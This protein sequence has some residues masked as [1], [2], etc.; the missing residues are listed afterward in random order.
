M[1]YGLK[2]KN[3]NGQIQIDATYKNYCLYEHGENVSTILLE[4]TGAI[5][6][7][8]ITFNNATP[9]PPLIAIKPSASIYCGLYSYTKSGNNYTGFIVR[10]EAG[11]SATIDWMAFVPNETASSAAY[12]MRVY[13]ASGVLVFDSGYS[14]MVILDVDTATPGY[15]SV[16]TITHPSNANAYFIMHSYG[17]Y[18]LTSAGGPT[19]II[20]RL[21]I[22]MFKYLSDT[23][24]SFGGKM[25]R[26]DFA[27]SYSLP[28]G[29]YWPSSWT[30][31]TIK[32]A[33]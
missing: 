6:E 21:F 14:P 12:G 5:R 30:I 7:A 18:L 4:G 9:Y 31:L 32:K 33:F 29:G 23:Q 24:V 10:S 13:N 22:A 16:E 27:G 25:H 20:T 1:G 26:I 3:S 11:Y 17:A 2:V 8:T 15:N 28:F 19:G